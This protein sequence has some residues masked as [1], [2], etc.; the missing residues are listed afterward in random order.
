MKVNNIEFINNLIRLDIPRDEDEQF[1]LVNKSN[2][3]F[4]LNQVKGNK[5][6]TF[7]K[8]EWYRIMECMH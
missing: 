7:L 1:A 4:L 5:F 2:D 8:L 3:I 6:G